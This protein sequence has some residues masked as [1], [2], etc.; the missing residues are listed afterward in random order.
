MLKAP[1]K[2][3]HMSPSHRQTIINIIKVDILSVLYQVYTDI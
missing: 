2:L 3:E 1:K